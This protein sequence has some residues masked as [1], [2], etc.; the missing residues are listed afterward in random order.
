RTHID[1]TAHPSPPPQCPTAYATLFP[2]TP[3]FRSLPRLVGARPARLGARAR[4]C[5]AGRRRARR[6]GG[7]RAR[8]GRGHPHAPPP[9]AGS[10]TDRKSTRLNSS[11]LGI[12]YAV[13]C[14]EKKSMQPKLV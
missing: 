11:H 8:R 2:S 1:G 13:F 9:S 10:A 7:R 3:L 6:P 12:S 4:D 5:Q 14:L